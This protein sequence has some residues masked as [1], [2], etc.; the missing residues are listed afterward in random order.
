M[1]VPL[2]LVLGGRVILLRG[3]R[4]DSQPVIEDVIRL[5]ILR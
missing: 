1:A 2:F 5:L 4:M 3:N